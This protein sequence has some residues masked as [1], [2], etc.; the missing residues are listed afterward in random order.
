MK[1][2]KDTTK[3]TICVK[4]TNDDNVEEKGIYYA[5]ANE[6]RISKDRIPYIKKLVAFKGGKPIAFCKGYFVYN[7]RTGRS[8]FNIDKILDVKDVI[9]N[10]MSKYCTI[11]YANL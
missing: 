6:W 1:N 3:N 5:V 7:D 4:I 11:Q 10:K 2:L 9:D 8:K